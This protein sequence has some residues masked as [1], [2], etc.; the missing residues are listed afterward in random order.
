MNKDRSIKEYIYN[1]AGA[2]R[3]ID[4]LLFIAKDLR[5]S[6]IHCDPRNSDILI[7]MR[8]DGL[9]IEIGTL[10]K[11]LL[12]EFITRLKIL[13]S[14]RTD[15]HSVPQ[16]GR[17]KTD[18]EGKIFNIRIS[19][20]PTYYGENAVIRLLPSR[21]NFI[22][23]FASLGFLPEQ[24]QMISDAMSK[25]TGLIIVTGP[26]GSGKTTTL[27]TCLSQKVG[28]PLSIVTL[29]DPPEYELPGVTQ[30]YI[31]HSHG[32]T[33]AS[34]LRSVLRQDPD[35][36]M[37]GEIRDNETARMAVHTSLTG[38]LVLTSLHTNSAVDTITRLLDMGIDRYLLSATLRLIIAQRLV[39]KL[40]E[41]CDG[42]GCDMCNQIGYR[43]RVVISEVLPI[44]DS[45]AKL[46][47]D[48]ANSETIL[49]R[50]KSLGFVPLEIDGKEKV[51]WGV[52][53]KVELE[54]ALND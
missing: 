38:H 24:V 15:I 19:F 41:D 16:D 51:S 42:D 23:S 39:R 44:D 11:T 22:H 12:D 3:T 47:E 49:D 32:V 30:I 6:D 29:E 28:E 46:I 48:G 33:F 20:M 35:V 1:G 36:I 53:S 26:T 2:S 54:R 9:I 45:I 17:W 40:C 25:N 8:I 4:E 43:G 18:I 50:A 52:T 27:H 5:A 34:G 21:S 31:K 14:T 7:R 13:S 10:P 37:V